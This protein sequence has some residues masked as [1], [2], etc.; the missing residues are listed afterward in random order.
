MAVGNSRSRAYRIRVVDGWL[1]PRHTDM[2][3]IESKILVDLYEPNGGDYW[4]KI[5]RFNLKTI[6][7]KIL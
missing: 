6:K 3:D 1:D 5:G 4:R 2:H 7:R